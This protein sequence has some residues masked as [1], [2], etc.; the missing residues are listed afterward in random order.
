MTAGF[1]TS[2]NYIDQLTEEQWS[3]AKCKWFFG[4]LRKKRLIRK[5]EYSNLT[6]TTFGPIEIIILMDD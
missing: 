3:K 4:K 2:N 5:I 6:Y 1:P